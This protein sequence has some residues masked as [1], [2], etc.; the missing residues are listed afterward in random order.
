MSRTTLVALSAFDQLGFENCSFTIGYVVKSVDVPSLQAAAIRVI[1]KWR[2][3]AGSVQWSK[4]LSTWCIAVPL[5]GDVSERLKFTTSQSPDDLDSRF[6]VNKDASAAILSCP[7][8]KYFRHP[9]VPT[10]LSSFSRHKAPILSLHVTKFANYTCVGITVPHGLFDAVGAGQIIRSLRCELRG[11]SWDVPSFSETN[12]LQVAFE[13]IVAS[14]RTHHNS[15]KFY[16]E[17]LDRLKRAF[18]A[19]SLR[20]LLTCGIM[21]VYEMVWQRSENKAVYLGGDV[22]KNLI[23]VVKGEVESSGAGWVS[24][25]DVLTSWFL[26]S[27]YA[28]EVDSNFVAMCGTASIR[29]LLAEKYP[30]MERYC[31]ESGSIV[32]QTKELAQK[33]LAEIAVLHRKA[34]ARTREAAYI[35]DYNDILVQRATTFPGAEMGFDPVIFTNQVIGRFDEADFGS[36]ISAL[37]FWV[38][39][40]ILPFPVVTINK[41]GEGYI[42]QG[43]VRRARWNAISDVL[44]L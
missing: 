19:P 26:K 32:V 1:G 35:K 37:W 8:V 12:V 41:L 38:T 17:M 18:V 27:S 4:Q 16:S 10:S 23:E 3:L 30:Q 44:G 28:H 9:S 24:T 22:L 40:S 21:F 43:T 36:E 42:L 15:D 34:I 31:R 7:P 29:Q 14:P 20:N 33:S 13:D 2:L 39:P 5:E 6:W 11:E 25:A